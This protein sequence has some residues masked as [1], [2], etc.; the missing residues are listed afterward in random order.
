[1]LSQ[2]VFVLEGLFAE[3]TFTWRLRRVLCA[4]MPPKVHRC[5][6]EL[7]V[8]ALCPLVVRIIAGLLFAIYKIGFW[9]ILGK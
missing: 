9:K 6:D 1:M 5:Y 2:A 8:R 7:A 4:H 3:I